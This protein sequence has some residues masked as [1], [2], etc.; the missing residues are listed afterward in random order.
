MQP[1]YGIHQ[2]SE[3]S[4]QPEHFF[5]TSKCSYLQTV[6]RAD[7]IFRLKGTPLARGLGLGI[8]SDSQPSHVMTVSSVLR[9]VVLIIHVFPQG[10]DKLHAQNITGKGIKIGMYVFSTFSIPFVL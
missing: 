8:P 4:A 3:P 2:E 1:C 9:V 10:V 7:K 5:L 6:I